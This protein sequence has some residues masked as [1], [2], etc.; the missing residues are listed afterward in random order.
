MGNNSIIFPKIVINIYAIWQGMTMTSKTIKTVLFASLIVAMIL[1]F[2][3][4]QIADAIATNDLA[5][6]KAKIKDTIKAKMIEQSNKDKLEKDNN[7]K[8][9]A[10]EYGI[11]YN[12]FFEENGKL[13]VGIDAGKALEFQK[14]YSVNEVKSDL[15]TDSDLEVRYYGFDRES[16]LRAGDALV[17]GAYSATITLVRND[18][19]ITTGHN[20]AVNDI[21][22]A[23][24]VGG[25]PCT[26]VKITNDPYSNPQIADASYGVDI[27]VAGCD[28]AY[29]NNSLHYNGNNYSVTDG[30]S[31]DITLNKFIRMA[32]ITTPNS[33][34]YIL[35]TDVTAKD[36][37]G[38]LD[39]Q[40]V[41]NYASAGGDSG[42]PVFT[43][44]SG[45]SVKILGQH[46]G[47]FCLVDLNSG[48]PSTYPQWCTNTQT[49]EGALT[50]FSPWPAVKTKLGI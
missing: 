26:E 6:K 20:I 4:L 37:L 42:A 39:D 43:I 32:G 3:S 31:S 14:K 33:S 5:N 16:D 21:L 46:V 11:P 9:A 8:Y 34:G 25:A 41:A 50:I 27:V 7:L 24:L 30:T 18:K 17:N 29:I 44:T 10:Q 13:V 2:S 12:V 36:G 48:H 35:D 15:L 1:P 28:H 19:I 40:V 22:T 38:V 45:T 49:G 23:G 47:K